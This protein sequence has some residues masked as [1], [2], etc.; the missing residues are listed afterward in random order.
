MNDP[1]AAPAASS[2]APRRRWLAGVALAAAFAVGGL[3]GAALS[4]AAQD[5]GPMM[6]H[7]GGMHGPAMMHH[8]EAVLDGVGATPDQK[9]RIEGILHTELEPAMAAHHD[10]GAVHTQ[11]FA[12]LTAP[13]I[14]RGALE[15]LRA[16]EIAKLDESSHAVTRAMA[17]A[18]EVLT[19]AQRVKLGEMIKAHHHE[20]EGH[21]G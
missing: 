9:T 19:P 5:A 2:P 3:S 15:Q 17:D 4:A 11:L 13:T 1:A 7:H 8:L 14:D 20:G 21:E 6:M 10:M 12:I 16:G 18:A